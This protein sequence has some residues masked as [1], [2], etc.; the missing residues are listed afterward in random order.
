MSD[1]PESRILLGRIGPAHGIRGEVVV[2]SF[3]AD[4]ADIASYGLLTDESGARSFR[5]RVMRVTPKGVVARVEGVADRTAAESLRGLDLYVA[6]ERLPRARKDEFY[7]AD[8]IG[9]SAV[10]PEGTV[11]GHIVAVDNFG[12][13]DLLEI[14]LAEQL[15]TIFVAFTQACVPEIDVEA[16]RVVVRLPVD[17]PDE[18]GEDEDV[19]ADAPPPDDAD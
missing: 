3:T 16:G 4:P 11:L 19:D 5:L 7:H 1:L 2:Q 8:L 18:C 17:A 12:A 10:S 13:G 6:R 15:Q 9:L 14:R